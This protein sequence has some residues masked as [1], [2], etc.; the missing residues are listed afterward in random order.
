MCFPNCKLVSDTV[1]KDIEIT[2]FQ[3]GPGG[4]MFAID[5]NGM[6]IFHPRLKTVV[7]SIRLLVIKKLYHY[8]YPIVCLMKVVR[9][10]SSSVPGRP[11]I[12][13]GNS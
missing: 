4:Y 10:L 11:Q 12:F 1:L 9:Q 13:L 8:T 6:V 2:F 3:V 7:C 5:N